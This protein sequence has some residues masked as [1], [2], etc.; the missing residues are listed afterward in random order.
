[1][2][3]I[4]IHINDTNKLNSIKDLCSKLGIQIETIGNKDLGRSILSIISGDEKLPAKI[5]IPLMYNMP[6]V[7]IFRGF[8]ET[9]L[10]SFLSEYK[11]A[12]IEKVAL[13]AMVTPYNV[14]WTLY[15]L[16]EHLKEEASMR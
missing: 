10:K 6:D 3:T 8:D 9:E 11:N 12:G 1:M 14:V 4:F 2:R 13:K 7:M 15:Y 16:I 5:D